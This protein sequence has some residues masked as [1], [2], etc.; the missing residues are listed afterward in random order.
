M[1]PSSVNSLKII[2]PS[3]CA[4]PSYG[5]NYL[6]NV[7]R[8][9]SHYLK[10]KR[11]QIINADGRKGYSEG[12]PYDVIYLGGGMLFTSINFLIFII[13]AVSETPQILVDQL[14]MGGTLV[15]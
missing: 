9:H 10:S 15:L 6:V 11:I 12:A 8:S 14:A 2:S 1:W 7:I 3:I 5:I 4:L 13:K